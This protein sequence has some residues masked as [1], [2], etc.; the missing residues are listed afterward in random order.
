MIRFSMVSGCSLLAA[1]CGGDGGGESFYLGLKHT[2]AANLGDGGPFVRATRQGA[3]IMLRTALVL[4]CILVAACGNDGGGTPTDDLNDKELGEE[5]VA[6]LKECG[7]Y[8]A[9]QNPEEDSLQDEFD[10]CV[11]RCLIE[12]GNCD[13]VQALQCD[14]D[15]PTGDPLV[16]CLVDC[17]LDPADGF[18]CDGQRIPFA[19]VCDGSRDC[20]KAE[21]EQNCEP[22]VCEN[23]EKVVGKDLRCDNVA[24]CR[25]GSDED[26]C[27]FTCDSTT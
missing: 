12:E 3:R 19:L 24:Q 26:G 8:S 13:V 23:G 17:P 2:P 6:K 5:A 27:P 4:S 18:E 25:D 7:V 11:A 1:V 9:P 22:Y 10:R 21:E 20:P 15:P 16:R 14:E